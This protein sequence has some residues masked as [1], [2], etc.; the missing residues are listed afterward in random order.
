VPVSEQDFAG[1]D[2]K[3][4]YERYLP[5]A[6][7]HEHY[8]NLIGADEAVP[9]IATRTLLAVYKWP[10]GSFRYRRIARFIETFFDRS[11]NLK[12][13]ARHAKWRELNLAA[14]VPGW[15]RFD[16]A[17]EWLAAHKDSNAASP[18][19]DDGRESQIRESFE[20]FLTRHEQLSGEKPKTDEETERLYQRFQ[21]FMAFQ[22]A[23]VDE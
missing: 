14:E 5:G 19:A 3:P 12:H 1:S 15:T 11:E 22:D 2:A 20:K 10:Q 8:P 23:R 17:G 9:T 13:E 7:T 6:L 18:A 4:L 16:A 21:Q